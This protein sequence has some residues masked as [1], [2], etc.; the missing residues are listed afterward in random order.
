[1]SLQHTM[2]GREKMKRFSL[3][4]ILLCVFTVQIFAFSARAAEP[5]RIGYIPVI[6]SSAL[7]VIDGKGWAHDAG[8]TLQPVR[9]TSGPQ[10]LQ[11]LVSGR[12]DAYVAGVLP[13]LQ[14]RAHGV[15]VKVITAA[16][17]EELE[18][19]S[20]GSLAALLTQNEEKTPASSDVKTL[21]E[22][23][24]KQQSRNVRIAAQP[25][26]S[27]PYTVLR[28]WLLQQVKISPPLTNSVS[29]VGIDIDAAQQ[30]FLAG[31]VDAAILREPALTV[32]RNR[33]PE[34][35]ILAT[36]HDLMPDQPG[37]VLAVVAPEDPAHRDWALKL[38]QLF[39]RATTFLSEH[40]EEAAPFV[41]KV[42]GGGLLSE[43]IMTQALTHASSH[44]IS[45]PQ[46]IVKGVAELQNFEAEQ[47]LLRKTEPV[48]ALFDLDM[49]RQ[50]QK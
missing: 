46:R 26:G 36:G 14:A 10:A 20:R 9:F 21:F 38:G 32:I 25:P 47:G 16:S 37:S 40:P 8:L 7:F 28:Y 29:V 13:L 19:I 45:D 39:V 5:I 23:F 1:M 6:G 31:A 41:T 4:A 49:W 43:S 2:N 3:K 42:L 34:S 12:I 22:T 11:A 15:D 48:D 17:V 27:V 24:K 50:I 30:A 35:K 44:F 33:L 18:V